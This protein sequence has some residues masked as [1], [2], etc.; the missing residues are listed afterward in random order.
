MISDY[1]SKFESFKKFEYNESVYFLK[2][3]FDFRDYN[4]S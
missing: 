3:F 1:F 2:I 4:N